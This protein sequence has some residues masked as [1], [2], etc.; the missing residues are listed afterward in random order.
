[1][2]QR[3]AVALL[4]ALAAF[5]PP[6][7][8]PAPE[9]PVF[10]SDVAVVMLPVFVVDRDGRAVRGLRAEDFEVVEEGRRAEVVS[11]RY[12]DTSDDEAQEEIKEAS[13]ARRRFLLV[14]DRSFTD[15]AGIQRAQQAA[16]DFVRTKL[17][18]SDLVAVA[19]FD[20]NNGLKLLANFTDDRVRLARIVE[21]SHSPRLV[22]ISDPLALAVDMTALDAMI[23][24][25]LRGGGSTG[26]DTAGLTRVLID[27]M[28]AAEVESYR[29]NIMTLAGSFQDLAR[30]L[31]S[32]D[33]RKQVLFFSGGF[34]ARLLIGESGEEQ[35]STA[36]SSA[37]GRLW[38][39]D[40]TT[41][42]GDTRVRNAIMEMTREFTRADA[43]IHTIDVTGLGRD[44]SLTQQHITVDPHRDTGGRESLGLLAAETGGRLFKDSNDLRNAMAEMMEMTS[45]YYVL[46]FQ[47]TQGRT[48]GAFHKVKV[49]VARKGVKVSHRP[50]YHERVP[51]S[52]QPLLQ[53]QFEAA[54]LVMG[55][56]GVD[57]LEF[58]TL[59]L[60]F[61]SRA[62][63]QDLGIVVQV[64]AS[65]LAV[66]DGKPPALEVYA[67][68]VA[69][70]GSVHDNIA[71]LA[72]F[73]PARQ[74]A[75]RGVSLH[76][77]LS[78]V[79]GRYTIRMMVT[80]RESGLTGVQVLDVNVPP[81]DARA[82]FLLP[83][84][85]VDDSE[86]WTML[87]MAR[88]KDGAK[89]SPFQLAGKPFVPRASFEVHPG[90]TEKMVLVAF[91]KERE[92]DP[93]TDVQLRSSLTGAGG[94]AV[95]AGAVRIAKVF[96]QADGRRVYLLDYVPESL[97]PGDYT[98]RIALDEG[99]ERI[100]SYSLLRVRTA[101]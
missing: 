53:R 48:P 88:T 3:P 42:F 84:I 23:A 58:S 55:G 36:Q 70:D 96:R 73:D 31:R 68:A 20:V 15:L 94:Q 13:A 25:G 26:T 5:L 83:P 40:G 72:R 45:R 64:P 19:S 56:G 9:K 59:C 17:A 30:A 49:K 67:Y 97:A 54:Q 50:G 22:A 61:P 6:R 41:R 98:L 28:R 101:S 87:E 16:L 75:M 51:L 8:H 60:P 66:R 99:G 85:V 62:E 38:E 81:F 52:G 89:T 29:T 86:A 11:F 46:G 90:S 32:V 78:V 34:D 100:E 35:R 76:G 74:G 63:K 2:R 91:E 44:R 4:V 37:A 80:E 57:D 33:G 93:A 82:G 18:S 10:S 92:G 27:R 79:P 1:M 71:Q 69:E 24:T 43:I 47:P 39:I 12:V 95:P 7:A 14:F 77:V 21:A 65:V